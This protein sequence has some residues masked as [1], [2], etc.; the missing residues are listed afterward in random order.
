MP[1]DPLLAK[2]Q[3]RYGPDGVVDVFKG[4]GMVP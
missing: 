3:A 2:L 4:T 1:F